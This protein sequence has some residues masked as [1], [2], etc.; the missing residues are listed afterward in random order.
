MSV[1]MPPE[2]WPYIQWAVYRDADGQ[3]LSVSCGQ[4]PTMEGTIEHLPPGLSVSLMP[5]GTSFEAVRRYGFIDVDDPAKPIAYEADKLKA[6]GL[7]LADVLAGKLDAV[8]PVP[9]WDSWP[10]KKPRKAT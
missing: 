9:I 2:G 3:I 4:Q 10:I 7:T 1:P 6:D 8:P 5:E